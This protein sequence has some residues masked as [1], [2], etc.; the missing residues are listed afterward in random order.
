MWL[1][2]AAIGVAL[3]I[4]I[5]MGNTN[6]ALNKCMNEARD[7]AERIECAKVFQSRPWLHECPTPLKAEEKK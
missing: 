6:Q 5:V 7:H 2:I 4:T 3:A 1:A